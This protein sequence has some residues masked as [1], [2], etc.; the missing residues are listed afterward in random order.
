MNKE[1]KGFLSVILSDNETT[2]KCVIQDN[3][4]GRKKSAEINARKSETHKSLG[5]QI[6]QERLNL[7]NIQFKNKLEII[8]TD[9]ID[10]SGNPEGTKVEIIIP[11]LTK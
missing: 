3:G 8:T 10:S 6:T 4:I 7:L 2:V 1:S 9:I 5:A 11:K